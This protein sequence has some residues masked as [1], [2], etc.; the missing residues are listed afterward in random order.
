LWISWKMRKMVRIMQVS[1]SPRR[2]PS[3]RYASVR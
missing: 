1:S 3:V 2:P